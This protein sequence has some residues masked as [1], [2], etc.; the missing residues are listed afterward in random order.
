MSFVLFLYMN[1]NE[2]SRIN[3][4][5]INRHAYTDIDANKFIILKYIFIL[6]LITEL[7][8]EMK[9]RFNRMNSKS[10]V[11]LSE[12]YKCRVKRIT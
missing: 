2:S 11:Q 5:V 4:R 7:K 10:K 3:E 12:K 1:M 8:R 6:Y 9:C